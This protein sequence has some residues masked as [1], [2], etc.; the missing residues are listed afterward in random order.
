MGVAVDL[1]GDFIVADISAASLFRVKSTG[2]VTTIAGGLGRVSGVAIDESGNFVTVRLSPPAVLSVT[3]SG[4]VTTIA[5]GPALGMPLNTP[6][7]EAEGDIVFTDL[8]FGRLLRVAPS[9]V[10]TTIASGPLSQPNG[11]AID[12]S[13]DFVVADRAGAVFRVAA[14]GAV[15]T[16]DGPLVAPTGIAIDAAGDLFVPDVA[17]SRVVRVIPGEDVTIVASGLPLIAPNSAAVMPSDAV[18]PGSVEAFIDVKPGSDVNPINPWSQGVVPV[19]LLGSDTLDV[20][21]VDVTTLAF[22][23]P[24]AANALP[25]HDLSDPMTLAD[26]L[27]D[28]NGDDFTDLISHYRI[29]ETGIGSGEVE[30]CATGDLVDG[31]TFE[32]CDAITTQTPSSRCGLGFELALVLAPLGWATARRRRS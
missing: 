13:G 7:I 31:T 27:K 15:T 8:F 11:V 10:V 1:G 14:S 26:H 4:M 17:M 22:G 3:P 2:V 5:A 28:S 12:G 19:A 9:G 25:V 30:A 20:A 6:A 18:M 24:G 23:P 32:G 16:I 21:D 29:P